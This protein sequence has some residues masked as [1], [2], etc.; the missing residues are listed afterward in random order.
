MGLVQHLAVAIFGS[1]IVVGDRFVVQLS[2]SHVLTQRT[3]PHRV[4]TP[5]EFG[6]T[7]ALEEL[8]LLHGSG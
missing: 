7:L 1:L 6:E 2:G 5:L 4:N 8:P 3:L